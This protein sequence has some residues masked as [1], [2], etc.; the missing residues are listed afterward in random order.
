MAFQAVP[1]T[2]EIKVFQNVAGVSSPQT[3]F[4]LLDA[5]ALPLTQATADGIAD[6]VEARYEAD[7]AARLSTAWSLVKI[8]CTDLTTE[9]AA[10][11]NGAFDALAGADG[12]DLLATQ[13]CA[14]VNWKG[15]IRSRNFFGKTYLSGFSEAQSNGSPV[16]ALITAVN[17]WATNL[18]A[19]FAGASQ[20]LV[21][22]SRF[23][24][25]ELV[26]ARGGQTILRPKR[27]IGAALTSKITSGLCDQ[28]WH[29]QRRRGQAG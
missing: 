4:F 25:S 10:Q 1:D 19:D 27:R 18:I 26:P 20:G 6:T 5:A 21:T 11:F 13:E 3:T 7:L 15:A 12:A 8:Q 24:G 22:V 9:G 16:A 29:T 23:D 14:L 2:I 17:T 28:H